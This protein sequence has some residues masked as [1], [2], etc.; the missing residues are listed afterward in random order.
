MSFNKGLDTLVDAFV[1]LKRN[2]K[3][4]NARLRI[5]G[6]TS[7]DDEVFIN[8]IQQQLR[9]CGLNDDAEFLPT[10]DRDTK[11][12]F[13]QT[14]SVLSVPEKRPIAYGLYVLEAL[15]AGVPVVEPASGVFP[16]LLEITG[17]GVLCEPNNAGA[18]AAAME[19]LLLDPDYARQIGKR[20]RETVF[21]KFNVDQ[22][23]KAIVRICKE[24]IQQFR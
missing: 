2:E 24:L 4:K 8:R 17:G 3:L 10:F 5:A 22:T 13:L 11:L 1:I 23:A 7:G 14:L 20:G 6:G 16:E 9:S 12:E 21:G 19:Q 18:L 15:A